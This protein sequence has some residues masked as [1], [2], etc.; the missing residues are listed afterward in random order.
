MINVCVVTFNR[1]DMLRTM[2]RTLRAM[3]VVPM[4]Y[5]ID[6][7]GNFFKEDLRYSFP[8]TPFKLINLEGNSLA[9]AWNW[10]AQNVPEERV[11]TN[12]DVEFPPGSLEAMV[13]TP[14]D[15]V[16]LDDGKSSNFACF[17][18][19]DS[20]VKKV[21]LFDEKI[22]PDYLYFEDWD[23]YKRMLIAG[24]PIISVPGP[25]HKMSQ[26]LEAKT[27]EQSADHHIRFNIAKQNYLKKWNLNDT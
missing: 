12:D 15:F 20:C 25:I 10:F 23:Y 8:R 6:R 26:T 3:P 7:G 11:I 27:P 1:S 24:I 21:G 5:L 22:S 4:V 9:A 18:L 2:L 19:R 16:G 17:V 14:G 13:H